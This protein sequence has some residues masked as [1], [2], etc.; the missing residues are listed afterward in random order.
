MELLTLII[1]VMLVEA[2]LHYFPWRMLL[3]GKELPRLMAYTFGLLGMMVPLSVWLWRTGEVL[4]L[5]TLWVVIVSAG[6]AVFA[7]YGLDHYLD[8]A[9]QNTEVKEQVKLLLGNDGHARE[10]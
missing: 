9:M 7:L 1:L 2:L 8:V 4:V 5:Q 10:S 6:L 3:K